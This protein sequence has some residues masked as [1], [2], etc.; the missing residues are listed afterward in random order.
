MGNAE[1]GKH[2][3]TGVDWR[4]ESPELC[5]YRGSTG[6]RTSGWLAHERTGM[7]KAT[8][9]AS[10]FRFRGWN[11]LT[12]LEP[13]HSST[14]GPV[15]SSSSSGFRYHHQ[16]PV[17]SG[18]RGSSSCS[19]FWQKSA[20]VDWMV[21]L[22]G[23]GQRCAAGLQVQPS[24]GTQFMWISL[25]V[26]RMSSVTMICSPAFMETGIRQVSGQTDCDYFTCAWDVLLF[27]NYVKRAV[28]SGA[29]PCEGAVLFKVVFQTGRK[30]VQR[31]RRCTLWFQTRWRARTATAP[32]ER[33]RWPPENPPEPMPCWSA[34][35]ADRK[36]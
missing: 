22:E 9:E 32:G 36:Q 17:V 14:A 19:F 12:G 33:L 30:S 24:T 21:S 28:L 34:K 25:L 10:V 16:S 13:S 26:W 35:R 8:R 29:L 3:R 5:D 7:L 27:M 6:E 2:L 11:F 18:H 31:W 23:D 20:L 1:A 15:T 4:L